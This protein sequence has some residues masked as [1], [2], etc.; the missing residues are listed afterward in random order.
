MQSAPASRA[1]SRGGDLGAG[2]EAAAEAAEVDDLVGDLLETEGDR[3]GLHR[4]AALARVQ[5]SKVKPTGRA[6]L[7]RQIGA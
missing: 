6:T 2:P 5:S 3:Q 4:I 7:G 1:W